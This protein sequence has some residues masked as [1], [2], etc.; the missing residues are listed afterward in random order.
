MFMCGK[1]LPA[2]REGKQS[3]LC[4]ISFYIYSL[5]LPE[6]SFLITPVPLTRRNLI[7]LS[8]SKYK[9]VQAGV[10]LRYSFKFLHKIKLSEPLQQN[11]KSLHGFRNWWTHSDKSRSTAITCKMVSLAH[12]VP[13]PQIAGN[14]WVYSAEAQIMH[15]VLTLPQGAVL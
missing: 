3:Y 1:K 15:F 6:Q 12:K 2:G 13:E 8:L 9:Y 10:G 4:P 11:C 5:I 14:L 7:C